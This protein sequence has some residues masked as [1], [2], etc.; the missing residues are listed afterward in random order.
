[1]KVRYDEGVAIRID[2]EPCVAA[3][4]DD[5]EASVGEGIGQPLSLE[6]LI[7]R[8]PTPFRRRK[9]TQ[10]STI[11]QGLAARRGRRTW[12][13]SKLFAREPGGP[14]VWPVASCQL[15]RIGKARSRSQ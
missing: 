6:I 15:V 2:P 10:P 1:V 3:R 4:K 7:S 5:D 11:S 13:V 8:V 9:A 12:H 14:R